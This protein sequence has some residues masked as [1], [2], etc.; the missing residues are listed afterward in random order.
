MRTLTLLICL[1]ASAAVVAQDKPAAAQSPDNPFSTF[2]KLAFG[3]MKDILLRSAEKMPEENYSFKPIDT[4]RSYGQIVGHVADSQY[5]F[6]SVA[7]GE[8]NPDSEN[9]A[10]QDLEGRPDRGAQRVGCLLR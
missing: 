1:L 6:C 2:N 7:L 3:H 8:T 4:V 10:N 9:R 5:Y